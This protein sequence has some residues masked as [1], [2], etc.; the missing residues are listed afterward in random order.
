MVPRRVRYFRP[1]GPPCPPPLA[2]RILLEPRRRPGRAV[3]GRRPDHLRPARRRP[4]RP[5]PSRAGSLPGLVDAH[6]HVGLGAHGPVDEDVAEQQALADRDAGTLLLRDAGSPVRHPLVDDRDDLPKIIR[7][8]R[9]IARTRRYIRNYAH[10]IEPERPRR[11]RRPGGPARRRLGQ[12]GRRLDRPRR[13]ATWPPAGRATRSR[14][15]SPRPT[16]WAPGSPRT[17]SARTRLPDLVEAGID[18]IEHAHRPD[19]RPIAAVRRAG[20]RDRADPGQHR[21]LPGLRRRR[22][23]S[24]PRRPPRTCARLHEHALRDRPASAYD[25]GV[26]I[27]VGTDAGGTLPHGLVAR[28]VAELCTGRHAGRRRALA[29]ATWAAR[30]WLGRPGLEEGAPADLVVYAADPREDVGV[31]ASPDL[32]RAAGEA[33][34]MRPA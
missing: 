28:E 1:H 16:A 21:D 30:A 34:R 27:F 29:A 25:A 7:A 11:V 32:R 17:A 3:G 24:V 10:E 33:R 14:R 19:R 13:R 5:R 8:G 6:C 23:G 4:G 15:P 2:G 26:P 20:R 31:L 9:H 22:R 12:A 18:C